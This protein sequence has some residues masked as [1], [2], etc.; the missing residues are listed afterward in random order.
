MCTDINITSN[1]L[2]LS[3]QILVALPVSDTRYF[4][5]HTDALP[6]LHL[7]LRGSTPS[8]DLYLGN[9]ENGRILSYTTSNQLLLCHRLL[10]ALP[11]NT[12]KDH[13]GGLHQLYLLQRKE[14]V[15]DL[16]PGSP[17]G[18]LGN[19]YKNYSAREAI[20]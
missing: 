4:Q 1:Q 16:S 18:R 9:Q 13:S 10:P 5:R 2:H 12:P 3:H 15:A 6:Q 17:E 14:L 19:Q 11:V 8:V 7:L 20:A